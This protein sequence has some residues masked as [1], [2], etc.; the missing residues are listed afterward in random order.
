M[1]TKTEFLILPD[2]FP[3]REIDARETAFVEAVGV[4]T[5]DRG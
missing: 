5:E 4:V 3:C 2:S 1:L